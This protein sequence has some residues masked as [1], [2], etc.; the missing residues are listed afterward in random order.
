M[1]KLNIISQELKKEI[2]LISLY[3]LLRRLGFFVFSLLLI[4]AFA[5]QSSKMILQ[6]YS[7][8]TVNRESANLKNSEEYIQ[9]IKT[10][11]EK[12]DKVATVQKDAVSWTKLIK[13]LSDK[14]SD[15]IT[16]NQIAIDKKSDNFT[17]SGNAKSRDS[18]LALEKILEETGYFEEINLPI[19]SLLKKDDIAFS[20]NVKFV[21][22]EF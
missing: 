14:I 21:K 20:V 4:Y 18:L 15:D 17:I 9:K 5:F 2:K 7:L 11:N 8:D 3:K 10:I 22:Y 16:I 12:I 19:S 13:T 1:L 6:K